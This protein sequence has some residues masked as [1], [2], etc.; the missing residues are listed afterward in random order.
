MRQPI[1][2][3]PSAQRESMSPA[4]WCIHRILSSPSFRKRGCADN[5]QQHMLTACATKLS[6][7][8]R[9][10]L[11]ALGHKAYAPEDRAA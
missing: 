6:E 3:A 1:D 9:Q 11:V 8:D 10:R 4:A 2:Q 5:A 7:R